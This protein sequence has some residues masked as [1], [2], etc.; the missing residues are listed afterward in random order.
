MIVTEPTHFKQRDLSN[1]SL[2]TENGLGMETAVKNSHRGH[3]LNATVENVI[4]SQTYSIAFLFLFK[5]SRIMRN[6][7]CPRPNSYVVTVGL[8]NQVRK[9]Q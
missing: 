6:N 8:L 2:M 9:G 4:L 7:I 3:Q 5:K 1:G